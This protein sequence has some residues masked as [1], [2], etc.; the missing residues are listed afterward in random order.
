MVTVAQTL[1]AK[2]KDLGDG[3]VVGRVLPQLACRNVGPFVFLD[4]MGPVTLPAGR[5]VDVRPHPHIGLATV[6]W[7]FDGELVH[8]DSLGVTQAIRPGELNWMSAGR[9]I[10]HSERSSPE[11]RRDGARLHGL[12]FWVAL[13]RDA[14][15]SEPWFAHHAAGELPGWRDGGAQVHVLAG[16]CLGR[17]S[18]VRTASRLFYA[19]AELA[20]GAGLV[21]PDDH[22]ERAVYVVDGAVTL[23]G[24]DTPPRRLAVLGRGAT[25]LAAT[26][27][28]RVA[29]FG[30]DPLDGPR[31]LLWNFVASS[32]E[33]LDQARR[34]W[35]QGRFAEVPGDLE[36]IPFPT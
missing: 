23:D 28:A 36:R 11:A 18:P 14:E 31:H 13:P 32:R 19:V 34:D 33:R 5:G 27:P 16:T 9:G 3:L 10:V 21:I 2:A 4:H 35:D 15:D 7:L 12:Q 22:P 25:E 29:I 8:R 6:T 20:A 1:D 26:A 24:A 17:T 30:G